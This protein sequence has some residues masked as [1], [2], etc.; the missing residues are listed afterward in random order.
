MPEDPAGGAIEGPA[1]TALVSLIS[2][3]VGIV[4]KMII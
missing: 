2:D 3:F 1:N 4:V